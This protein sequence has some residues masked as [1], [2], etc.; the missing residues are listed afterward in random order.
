MLV[1]AFVAFPIPFAFITTSIFWEVAFIGCVVIASGW[2]KMLKDHETRKQ[3]RRFVRMLLVQLPLIFFYASYNAVFNRLCGIQQLAL[4]IL[5]PMAKFAFKILLQRAASDLNDYVPALLISIDVFDAIYLSKCMQSSG[6]LMTTCGV[7]VIDTAQNLYHIWHLQQLVDLTHKLQQQSGFKEQHTSLMSAVLEICSQP[8]LLLAGELE[9][10]ALRS[11]V[12]FGR[13]LSKSKLDIIETLGQRQIEIKNTTRKSRLSFLS[14]LKAFPLHS[15]IPGPT[16]KNA[17]MTATTGEFARLDQRRQVHTRTTLMKRSL[18]LLR[19]T[20]V[21]LLIEYIE[22][23][24]PI[25]YAVYL[26]IIFYLPT[27]QYYPEIHELTPSTLRLTVLKIVLYAGLE[28]LSLIWVHWMLKHRFQ[29]SGLRQLAFVLEEEQ[30]V[31]QASL[32][33]WTS[34]IFQF[35]LQHLGKTPV[36]EWGFYTYI[37]L[38]TY[39]D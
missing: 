9:R 4:V 23:A 20:E 11:C 30:L 26:P 37:C 22:C 15:I 19:M 35:T 10:L 17:H 13:V 16:I 31:V 39:R 33:T 36:L 5:L 38:K 1:A 27:G 34:V 8:E 25:L 24:I 29:L 12:T 21:I 28:L 7:L 32:L 6:S 18:D 2:E 3:V 14:S